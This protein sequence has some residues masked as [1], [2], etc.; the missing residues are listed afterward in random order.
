MKVNGVAGYSREKNRKY[1]GIRAWKKRKE[2]L[3]D[4]K[5]EIHGGEF[6]PTAE[7]EQNKEKL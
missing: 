6:G 3:M 4:I 1:N 2:E 7:L 5:Y